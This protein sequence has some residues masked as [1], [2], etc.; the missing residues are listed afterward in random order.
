MR[1]GLAELVT[2]AQATPAETVTIAEWLQIGTTLGVG[3]VLTLLVSTWLQRRR[4]SAEVDKTD[5]EAKGALN[6]AAAVAAQTASNLL[7]PLNNRL[8]ELD[9]QLSDVTA[10][11]EILKVEV[12]AVETREMELKSKLQTV[13]EQNKTLRAE[14]D[15]LTE[16]VDAL[17]V[18]N[19][20][21]KRRLDQS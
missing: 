20:D 12:H 13:E 16:R 6:Q 19:Q 1:M 18:E 11:N 7:A 17:V 21:L 3:S 15:R 4:T 2:I 14:V 5:G 9:R 10:E 8:T